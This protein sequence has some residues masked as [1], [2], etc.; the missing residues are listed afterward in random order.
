[1]SAKRPYA[2]SI[3]GF[4]P[5]GGAGIA[6][7]LK[8]FEAHKVNGLGV[9]SALTFQNES[10]FEGLEWTNR[11]NILKQLNV[12]TRKH[13]IEFIKMGLIENLDILDRLISSL[14]AQVA[15][16][17]VVWDPILKA[18]AGFEI[19]SKMDTDRL[20]DVCKNV[21]LTTPNTEEIRMLMSEQDEMKAAK[22]LSTF[23][24]VLLKGGHS[25]KEKG[26]DYLFTKEGKMFSF[27]P[28]TLSAFGKHGSGCVLS[29]AITANLAKG[30]SL[31]EACMK[32]KSYTEDFLM[33]NKSSLGYHKL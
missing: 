28:R 9:V 16:P 1:M 26:R 24:N 6:A 11:E 8:T 2:L 29:S 32:A 13:T 33:S 4:D 31:K 23:C 19:H 20:K 12:L 22:E 3:A 25:D 17:L 10:E 14:K 21:F 15:N 5:S 18:S 27:R 7:D 30:F